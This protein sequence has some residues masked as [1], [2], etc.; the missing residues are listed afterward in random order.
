MFDHADDI[1]WETIELVNQH[2]DLYYVAELKNIL[3]FGRKFALNPIEV[4]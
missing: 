2:F 4:L 3:N 1:Y